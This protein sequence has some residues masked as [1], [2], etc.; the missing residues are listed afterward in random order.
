MVAEKKIYFD[1][2]LMDVCIR[3]SCPETFL[4]SYLNLILISPD[5]KS[6]QSQHK[7]LHINTC[8]LLMLANI[9]FRIRIHQKHLGI[10]N[11][12]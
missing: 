5:S 4:I 6:R 10:H 11:T 3:W 12:A 7:V 1:H 8:T 9:L 2:L